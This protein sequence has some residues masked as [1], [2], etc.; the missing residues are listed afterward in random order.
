[1]GNQMKMGHPQNIQSF[2]TIIETGE[3]AKLRR[4]EYSERQQI[5][6]I[7]LGSLDMVS[8]MGLRRSDWGLSSCAV[9]VV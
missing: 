2:E 9:K 4:T 6:V 1:M 7:L 5:S 8:F 3:P